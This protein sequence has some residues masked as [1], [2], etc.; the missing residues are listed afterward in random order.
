MD[1]PCYQGWS[2]CLWVPSPPHV[3]CPVSPGKEALRD[4]LPL[5]HLRG[6]PEKGYVFVSNGFP[7]NWGQ[8][9]KVNPIG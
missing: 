6:S 4:V 5:A 2:A 9:V 1:L 3:A 8:K 7:D